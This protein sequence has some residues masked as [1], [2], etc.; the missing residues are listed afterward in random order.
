MGQIRVILL[1]SLLTALFLGVGYFFAGTTGMLLGL[2]M[3]FITNFFAYW[4][5]DSFVLKMYKARPFD[6]KEIKTII[7]NL[8]EKAGIPVPK[9]YIT[10]MDVPNAFATGRN[11]K[12]GAVCVTSGLVKMLNKNEIKGV[13]AHEIS[14]I[15]HK[16]TL[17]Q[18]MSA[19]IAGAITWLGYIFWFGDRRNRNII[20]YLLMFIAVPIASLLIRTAISR[21]REFYADK[22]GAEISD[23]LGLA[24]A[25]EKISSF[26]YNHPMRGNASTSHLFIINPFSARGLSSLFSTHPP[27]DERINRL[28]QMSI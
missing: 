1:I 25:L 9:L 10:E 22:Y 4:Y 5:S 15:K 7:K 12:H 28:R 11:P 8:A 23:P 19:T 18:T 26:A 2:I 3:A 20:S 13:L 21:N 6:N 27:T 17:L 24:S 14:H 16:D